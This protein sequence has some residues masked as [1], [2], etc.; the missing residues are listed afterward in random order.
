MDKVKSKRKTPKDYI[1][2]TCGKLSKTYA[3]H[4]YHITNH[5]C[6][7][8]KGAAH[9]CRMCFERFSMLIEL[10]RHIDLNMCY[11]I[12]NESTI[13]DL[14]DIDCGSIELLKEH[15]FTHIRN[16]SCPI[17]SHLRY[18]IPVN[19][20]EIDTSKH[21][22]ELET[23]VSKKTDKKI[24]N[25]N[26]MPRLRRKHPN[27]RNNN[28][29][30]LDDEE[31]VVIEPTNTR[32]DNTD[33]ENKLDKMIQ[34]RSTNTKTSIPATPPNLTKTEVEKIKSE[35]FENEYD[36][37]IQERDDFITNFKLEKNDNISHSQRSEKISTTDFDRKIKEMMENRDKGLVFN[38]DTP[39][40]ATHPL[41]NQSRTPCDVIGLGNMSNNENLD[42][43]LN[44]ELEQI[45]ME[46]SKIPKQAQPQVSTPAPAPAPIYIG[47]PKTLQEEFNEAKTFDLKMSNNNTWHSMINLINGTD[48]EKNFMKYLLDCTIHEYA[49]IHTFIKSSKQ[50]VIEKPKRNSLVKIWNNFNNYVNDKSRRNEMAINGKNLHNIIELFKHLVLAQSQ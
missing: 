17:V 5:V 12:M 37:I 30:D 47:K 13:C 7:F 31:E 36:N 26:I 4:Y 10:E 39:K 35:E 25:K 24:S 15:Q 20:I 42:L 40:T 33:V 3:A 48:M 6:K 21:Y 14:C 9:T 41:L 45:T 27:N 11:K 16:K 32:V 44:K 8:D 29:D 18:D 19:V 23:K 46:I 34:E 43:D 28:T 49:T 38:T 1:C 2:K 50:L 22:E